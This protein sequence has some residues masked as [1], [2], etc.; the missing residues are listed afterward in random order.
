MLEHN[1]IFQVFKIHYYFIKLS[2]QQVVAQPQ[3]LIKLQIFDTK[4]TRNPYTYYAQTTWFKH[5]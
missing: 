4:P 5:K 1:S 3:H 2:N